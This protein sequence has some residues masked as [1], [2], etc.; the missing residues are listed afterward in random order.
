MKNDT[1]RILE[2]L[3]Y[4][5]QQEK[6]TTDPE[7]QLLEQRRHILEGAFLN[8]HQNDHA[9]IVEVNDLLD[10]QTSLAEYRC[11]FQFS[12]GL[13]IGLELGGLDILREI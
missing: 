13:Q 2:K 8:A 6:L 3:A 12:L 10:A 7:C 5:Y 9:L 11:D 4:R 1:L